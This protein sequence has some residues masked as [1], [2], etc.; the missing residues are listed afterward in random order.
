MERRTLTPADFG[1]PAALA[2]RIC[3][4]ATARATAQSRARSSKARA[5]PRRDIVLVNAAA[6]LVACGRARD[7]REGM[8]EAAAAIDIGAALRKAEE[9]ARFTASLRAV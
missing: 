7:F 5:G 1:V 9:L 6:A 3:A 8:A 4:A 2:A